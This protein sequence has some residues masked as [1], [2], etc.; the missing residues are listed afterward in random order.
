M[1]N[2]CFFQCLGCI[3]RWWTWAWWCRWSS[4]GIRGSGCRSSSGWPGCCRS[5]SSRWTR[6][7]R[8]ICSCST[9]WPNSYRYRYL[10]ILLKILQRSTA[11]KKL[12]QLS[13]VSREKNGF[14]CS[15]NKCFLV[16][17]SELGNEIEQEKR[18]LKI[19]QMLGPFQIKFASDQGPLVRKRD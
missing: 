5:P 17:W 1:Q 13:R 8:R 10:G 9:K 6:S 16:Q 15:H 11:F 12:V 2:M 7:T 19:R 3:C 14:F 4:R 18:C